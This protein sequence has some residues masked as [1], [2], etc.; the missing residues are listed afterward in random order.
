MDIVGDAIRALRIGT[1]RSAR[2]YLYGRWGLRWDPSRGPGFNIH[3]VLEGTAWLVPDGHPPIPM[4]AGDVAF[5]SRT[6]AHGI[7]ESP[8]TPLID[9]PADEDEFW[10]GKHPDPVHGPDVARTVLIGGSYYMRDQRMHPLIESLPPV[11]RL[12]ARLADADPIGAIVGLLGK[13]HDDARLGST[14]AMPALLDLLL[15]Y[16]IRAAFE[17]ADAGNGWAAVLRDTS[18]SSALDNMQNRPEEPWT[19]ASLAAAAGM[20]RA[21]LARRFGELVGEPPMTYLTRW[22]MSLARSYLRE[23]DASLST[24]ARRV[25]YNSEFA[26]SKA[27]SREVGQSPSSFRRSREAD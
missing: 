12:P 7:A 13:E 23:T 27:F 1:P 22:R 9:V 4:E 3:V 10:F 14:A 19:I 17:Q 25:G 2:A 11:L 18:L 26:F 8:S 20:S 15:V 21:T 24:I 6:I 16:V 5:V